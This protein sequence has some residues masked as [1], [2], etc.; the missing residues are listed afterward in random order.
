MTLEKDKV[1]VAIPQWRLV[2]CEFLHREVQVKR[3][4]ISDVGYPVPEMWARLV[5][6][7]D[8]TQLFPAGSNITEVDPKLVE[9]ICT[10]AT[11][12]PTKVVE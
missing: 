8:G 4:T 10:L 5:R 2:F 9:E 1:S 7:G 3:P 11:A 6:D 12:T